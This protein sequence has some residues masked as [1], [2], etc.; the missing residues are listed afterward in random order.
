MKKTLA[1]VLALTLVLGMASTAFAAPGSE[2]ETGAGTIEFRDGDAPVIIDPPGEEE[3]PVDPERPIDPENPPV[4][5]EK[6]TD[7]PPVNPEGPNP[8]NWRISSDLN[9]DFGLQT[10]TGSNRT[11]SSYYHARS[12]NTR[13]AGVVVLNESVQSDWVLQVGMSGFTIGGSPTLAGFELDLIPY[14]IYTSSPGTPQ[15]VNTVTLEANGAP[16][17]IMTITPVSTIGA[18]WEGFLD[19]LG[20][21][22]QQTGEARAEMTWS[23]VI[24][25]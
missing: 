3:P 20:G 18:N 2:Q 9:L 6:P 25:A 8:E 24:P 17:T 22:V 1:F 5:P 11:Y 7:P 16:Q 4:E 21:S 14:S 10:I 13:F 15:T 19:V 23:I 12:D